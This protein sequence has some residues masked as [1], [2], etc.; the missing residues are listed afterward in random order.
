MEI[1]KATPINKEN[2]MFKSLL[3]PFIFLFFLFSV[4]NKKGREN[5]CG[6]RILD[7]GHINIDV[8]KVPALSK[9]MLSIIWF[10]YLF[11]LLQQIN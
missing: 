9:P 11:P 6:Q 1:G 4:L 2:L 7:V 5:S 10:F 3:S 8:W